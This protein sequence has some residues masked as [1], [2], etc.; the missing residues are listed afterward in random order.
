MST[1]RFTAPQAP[2]RAMAVP[3]DVGNVHWVRKPASESEVAAAGYWFISPEEAPE[4]IRVVSHADESVYVIEGRLRI[5]PEG[6]DA[7]ELI[8]GTA[9]T[10]NKGVVATWTVLEPTV[11]FFVYS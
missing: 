11:E 4:P 10:L 7:F 2:D 9:V 3:F 1:N 6:S 8:A 5:E